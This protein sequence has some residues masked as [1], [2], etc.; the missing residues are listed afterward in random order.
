LPDAATAAL[1]I[2]GHPLRDD[3]DAT[4]L[5]R[6][7]WVSGSV[8]FLTPLPLGANVE[9][10]SRV[11]D[12][13][14][15]YGPSGQLKFVEIEHLTLASGREAVLESQTIVYREAAQAPVAKPAAPPGEPELS[16]WTWRRRV[17]P[18]ESLLF[19]FSALTFNTHRIHYDMPYATQQEGYPGLVVQG[20][21]LATLLVDMCR[22][23]L[24]DQ[25][26]SQFRFRALAPAFAGDE[27]YL[28]GR[29]EAGAID[30]AVLGADGRI[31]VKATALAAT[32]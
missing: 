2:D 18:S 10:I 21:L 13:K 5:P 4:A 29:N 19:R 8:E 30:L 9:R 22:R 1:G 6:R 20:P 17:V 23:E 27:L 16:S 12:T 26:L 25:A 32:T 15:K 11:R 14:Y 3:D 24:G 7:M 31:L 28:V